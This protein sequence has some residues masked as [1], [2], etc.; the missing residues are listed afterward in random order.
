[1]AADRVLDRVLSLLRG[2]AKRGGGAIDEHLRWVA[3]QRS[4]QQRVRWPQ[5]RD[6]KAHATHGRSELTHAKVKWIT[7]L[8]RSPGSS[9]RKSAD[10]A[11][12][13]GAVGSAVWTEEESECTTLWAHPR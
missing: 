7:R 4:G 10:S 12:H 8:N 9:R 2:G 13:G 5:Q 11:T 1:M 3:A 6:V